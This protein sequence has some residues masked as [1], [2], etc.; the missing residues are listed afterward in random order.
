MT[1]AEEFVAIFYHLMSSADK[2]EIVSS[3]ELVYDVLTESEADSTVILAPLI[4]F[5]VGVTPK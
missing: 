4:D 3:A 5:L 2:V 1:F